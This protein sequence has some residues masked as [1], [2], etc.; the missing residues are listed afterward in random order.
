[1]TRITLTELA[2]VMGC[3]ADRAKA[4]VEAQA[5]RV[6]AYRDQHTGFFYADR[7]KLDRWALR[8]ARFLR[9]APRAA[10]GG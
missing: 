1:M 6:P 10:A 3:N 7:A 9:E 4:I 8:Y 5:K 2:S